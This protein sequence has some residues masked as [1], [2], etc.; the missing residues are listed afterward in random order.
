M[1]SSA[2]DRADAAT[3]VRG[4]ETRRASFPTERT[5]LLWLLVGRLVVALATLVWASLVWASHA[6]VAFIGTIGVVFALISTG[7]SAWTLF[8]RNTSHSRGFL[9]VQA[10]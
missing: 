7:Y 8:I 9:Q 3:N 1:A 6:S 2:A 4:R 5:L 10:L